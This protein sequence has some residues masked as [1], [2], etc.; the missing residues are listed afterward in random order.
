MAVH[1]IPTFSAPPTPVGGAKDR[2]PA[3]GVAEAAAVA[4]DE[5]RVSERAQ[6]LSRLA[7]DVDPTPDSLRRRASRLADELGKEL[8]GGGID[9]R[10]PLA[11]DVDAVEGTVRVRDVRADAQAIDA[12]LARRPDIVARIR[13][14]AVLQRHVESIEAS[15]GVAAARRATRDAA[16][17][18]GLIARFAP[19]ATGGD[20]ATGF[21]V[22]ERESAAAWTRQ[23]RAASAYSAVAGEIDVARL[24]PE[25]PRADRRGRG[26]SP[27]RDDAAQ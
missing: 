15:T 12:M 1:S 10:Q 3:P 20:P 2:R 26:G 25:A 21:A 4:R 13:D 24:V 7:A 9:A 27:A 16:E 19:P 17:A 5:V 6:V 11:F 22:I 23:L 18:S 8:R 14:V